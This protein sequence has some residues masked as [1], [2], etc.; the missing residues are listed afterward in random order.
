M[1]RTSKTVRRVVTVTDEAGRGSIE[2]D[3]VLSPVEPSVPSQGVE[4]TVLWVVEDSP[5][6]PEQGATPSSPLW[7]LGSFHP[8]G[9]RWTEMTI[10][11]GAKTIGMHKTD[12]VDLVLI[13]S[14]EIWLVM[15]DGSERRLSAGD[16]VVQRAA[17]HDW[18]NRSDAPC[19]MSVVIVSA[20]AK[21]A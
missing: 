16:S 2:S 13:T 7:Q 3:E 9:I 5:A 10:H 20:V 15:E 19:V 14:G 17:V 8:Q 1:S 21:D 6:K 18:D 11:P 12:T 4:A